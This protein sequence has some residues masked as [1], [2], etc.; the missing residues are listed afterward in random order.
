MN[1]AS[2]RAYSIAELDELRMQRER[3]NFTVVSAKVDLSI[4]ERIKLAMGVLDYNQDL[5]SF[6]DAKANTLLV[7]NSIFLA[8][9][10][11]AGLGKPLAL[12]SLVASAVVVLLCLRVVWARATS[13][14]ARE[15][16][17]LVYFGDIL[18]RNKAVNYL[19]DFR[20][21]TPD[22]VLQSTVMQIFGLAGVAERKYK[23]YAFAQFATV[24]SAAIWIANL[25]Q[26]ILSA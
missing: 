3:D 18:R 19:D 11:S 26:P 9:T 23:A 21:V 22:E 17:Q 8:T 6:S 5:I 10:A 24:V 4:Q 14:R 25:L 15:R 7:V 2:Q 1:T 20:S 13:T 12:A 16:G